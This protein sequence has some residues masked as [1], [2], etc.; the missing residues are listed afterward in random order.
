MKK[1]KNLGRSLSKAEQK[2]IVGGFDEGEC[3]CDPVI[4][5]ALSGPGKTCKCYDRPCGCKCQCA[6]VS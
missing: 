4:C 1:F 3:T 2:N 5:E 6:S